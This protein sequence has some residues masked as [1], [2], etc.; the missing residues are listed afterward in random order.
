MPR[1]TES[2]KEM[3][4][5]SISDDET[6]NKLPLGLQMIIRTSGLWGSACE[7]R[8]PIYG[9]LQST[10]WPSVISVDWFQVDEET[11]LEIEGNKVGV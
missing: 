11:W 4:K 10:H 6:Y 7:P 1:A 9:E 3:R 2:K 8:Y 5:Y